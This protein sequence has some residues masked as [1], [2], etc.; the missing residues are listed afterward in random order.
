[1][2]LSYFILI[3]ASSEEACLC[4][5]NNVLVNLDRH[6]LKSQ[7][8]QQ[9]NNKIITFRDVFRQASKIII[10]FNNPNFDVTYSF[11]QTENYIYF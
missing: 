6:A 7:S 11:F 5:I 2:Q 10:S 3:V 4:V 8:P 9:S 1:M